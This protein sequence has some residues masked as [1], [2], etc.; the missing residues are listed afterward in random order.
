VIL[1]VIITVN[2]LLR[3][4]VSAAQDS[5]LGTNIWW[6][7]FIADVKDALLILVLTQRISLAGILE[8]PLTFHT[9]QQKTN[10]VALSPQANYT[11]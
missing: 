3:Y 1:N 11:D 8:V 2:W 9:K 7:L 10:S 4:V 6:L 5:E